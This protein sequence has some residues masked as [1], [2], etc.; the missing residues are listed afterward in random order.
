MV[1]T[2]LPES[3]SIVREVMTGVRVASSLIRSAAASTS[4]SVIARAMLV[5]VERRI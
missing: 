2:N 3:L 1:Q 4:A 5:D